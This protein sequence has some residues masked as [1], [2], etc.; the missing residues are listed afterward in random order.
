MADAGIAFTNANDYVLVIFVHDPNQ[1]M[2]EA[3][4]Q[5]IAAISRAIY[6]FF[7]IQIQ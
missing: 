3:V 4:N 7:N 1:I 6:N 5:M 2:W